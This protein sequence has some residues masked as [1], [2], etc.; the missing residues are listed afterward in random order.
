[1]ISKLYVILGTMTTKINE[2]STDFPTAGIIE[3]KHTGKFTGKGF[4]FMGYYTLIG[5]EKENKIRLIKIYDEKPENIVLNLN[6]INNKIWI[7]EWKYK[8][9]KGTVEFT[10]NEIQTNQI[11]LRIFEAYKQGRP[12]KKRRRN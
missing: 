3:Q 8:A 10:I 4:D 7:G 1:M 2:K 5:D 11:N 9:R 6:K 12:P